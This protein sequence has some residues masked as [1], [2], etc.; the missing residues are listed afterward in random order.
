MHT[1]RHLLLAPALLCC[2]L[3][4]GGHGAR[5]QQKSAT[6]KP[7]ATPARP[8]A[9]PPGPQKIVVQG[10]ELEFT[11]NPVADGDAAGAAVMEGRDSLVRFRVTDTTTGTPLAGVR[12]SAWLSLREGAGGD[13]KVCREK[14]QSFLQGSLRARPDVDLN[15]YYILALN[16]EPNISV[17]DPLLGFGGSKL[18]TLV[19]LRAPGADWVAT[20]DQKRL[21]V[22]MPDVN[23]VAVVDTKTWQVVSNIDTGARPTRLALQPDEKYLWVG[24]DE[25]AES[26]VTV[27]DAAAGKVAARVP[28]GAGRHDIALGDDNRTAYV[29]NRDAGTLAVIDVRTLTKVGEVKVGSTASAVAFSPLGK[30]VYVSDEAG[31]QIVVVDGRAPKVLARVAVAP[32]VGRVRFAPGGRYGFAPN[33]SASSVHIFDASANRLLHTR[34]VGKQPDQIAFTRDYA[35]VRSAG[36]VEVSIIRLG[37][38]G[39]ELNVTTFPGGQRAPAEA[40][41]PASAADS[42]APTPEGNSMLVANAADRQIYYYTEGMAAPMGNFQNYRR[43][44]RAV[45]VIDR[46]LREVSAGVYEAVARLPRSGVYDVALLLDSPR[47]THCFEAE[48]APDPAAK[49]ERAVALRVEYL[50]REKPLRVGSDYNLRFRLFDTATNKPKDGL[51]D[52]RVLT[53]LSPGVWQRRD[54]ARGVGGG[55]YEL[56]VNVPEPG[57]YMFFVESKSQDVA[58]RQL[59]YLALQASEKDGAAAPATSK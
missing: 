33:A 46:S 44:P 3:A 36:A 58:F 24:T 47:V 8:E 42:M 59:P 27:I 6:P 23:Q 38:V 19:F 16:Q 17:I 34:S 49:R 7:A 26:G 22:S 53:F 35:Y 1:T 12:P 9:K 50:G 13:A 40:R 37:T 29:T 41:A 56:T 43:D 5:A 57:F 20:R 45:L 55:V 4:H 31:G 54:F 51:D 48:A 30:T 2:A 18:V 25:G 39:G 11:I 21:F 32:G 10:V 15:S 14:V 28:T 52:V